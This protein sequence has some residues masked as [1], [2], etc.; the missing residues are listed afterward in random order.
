MLDYWHKHPPVHKL[1]ASFV[2]YEPSSNA[3]QSKQ[4]N[5]QNANLDSFLETI[6]QPVF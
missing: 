5:N 1:V 3:Q 6:I 2:G 4:A